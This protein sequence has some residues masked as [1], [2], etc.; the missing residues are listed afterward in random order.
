MNTLKFRNE[1]F[2]IATSWTNCIKWSFK[3][4]FGDFEYKI[5]LET[6]KIMCGKKFKRTDHIDGK[7]IGF[8]VMESVFLA[9]S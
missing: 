8:K 5:L 7:I 1:H 9:P 6:I 2:E 4:L 3:I